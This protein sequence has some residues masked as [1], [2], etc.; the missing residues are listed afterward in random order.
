MAISSAAEEET[1]KG[2]FLHHWRV[3]CFLCWE[4]TTNSV[5]QNKVSR[6]LGL[7]KKLCV[8]LKMLTRLCF[9][10]PHYGIAC[11]Q[12]NYI[13]FFRITVCCSC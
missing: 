2:D 12:K 9:C 10:S 11:S 7:T 6:K 3:G 1:A 5:Y 13:L 4:L 8:G